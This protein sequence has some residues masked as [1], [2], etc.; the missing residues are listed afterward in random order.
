MFTG[1]SDCLVE[2]VGAQTPGEYAVSEDLIAHH[3]NIRLRAHQAQATTGSPGLVA[4]VD[5]A[6]DAPRR[7]VRQ[8]DHSVHGRQGLKLID[9]SIDLLGELRWWGSLTHDRV[10]GVEYQNQTTHGLLSANSHLR[11]ILDRRDWHSSE[12]DRSDGLEGRFRR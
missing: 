7:P 9:R 6:L 8:D 4:P 1:L 12:H 5:H 2:E 10:V 3:P 11:E